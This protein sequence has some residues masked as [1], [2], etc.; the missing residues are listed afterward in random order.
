MKM[1]DFAQYL[2]TISFDE[3]LHQVRQLSYER[4]IANEQTFHG[5]H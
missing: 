5:I 4:I 2:T 3:A 1:E